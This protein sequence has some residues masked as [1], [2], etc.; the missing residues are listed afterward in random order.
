MGDRTTVHL[1]IP[2]SYEESAKTLVDFSSYSDR[3]T[4][5]PGLVCLRFDDVDSGELEFEKE[6]MSMGIPYDKSW[7]AGA[8]YTSGKEYF[9][10][11]ADGTAVSLVVY[12]ED[13]NPSLQHLMELFHSHE[14]LQAYIRAHYQKVTPLPWDSQVEYSKRYRLKKLITAAE[15]NP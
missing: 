9:R 3:F 2:E 13:K 6:L 14:A 8:N 1:S 10:F 12:D 7:D 15:A 5:K 11:E 4:K